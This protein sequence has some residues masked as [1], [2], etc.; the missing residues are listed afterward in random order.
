MNSP[1]LIHTSS[2]PFVRTISDDGSSEWVNVLVPG[3]GDCQVQRCDLEIENDV[4]F[5]QGSC[6]LLA[7]T[8][9][10]IFVLTLM[11]WTAYSHLSR[12]LELR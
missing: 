5:A 12:P 1:V 2:I 4:G 7:L 8:L 6:P 11:K 3:I 9:D 10:F